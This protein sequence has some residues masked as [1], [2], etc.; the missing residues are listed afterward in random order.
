MQSIKNERTH[1]QAGLVD[2]DYAWFVAWLAGYITNPRSVEIRHT[3]QNPDAWLVRT[4]SGR[5]LVAPSAYK[6]VEDCD[7]IK[8]KQAVRFFSHKDG[9]QLR[10][11][12][13]VS[14]RIKYHHIHADRFFESAQEYL[15]KETLI[16]VISQ[17]SEDR[18]KN[19]GAPVTEIRKLR[20]V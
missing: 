10:V 12:E 11:P 3:S 8:F 4:H 13:N 16:A 9:V 18:I 6:Y 7:L 19:Q 5:L 1:F 17:D 20:V 15:D 14:R 2:S